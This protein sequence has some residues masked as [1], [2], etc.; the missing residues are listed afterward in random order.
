VLYFENNENFAKEVKELC[1]KLQATVC[2]EC[3]GGKICGVIFNNLPQ[4]STLIVYGTLSGQDIEG[5]N[6]V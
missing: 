2:F 1:E 4:K 6:G 3:I 5:I